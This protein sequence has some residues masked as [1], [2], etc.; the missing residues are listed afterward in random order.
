LGTA[1]GLLVSSVAFILLYV[2]M[3]RAELAS[4]RGKAAAQVNRL[5]QT[6]LE[7]AM[8]KR[9]LEGLRFIVDRLGRQPGVEAVFITNPGGEIRFASEPALLERSLLA[10][11][12]VRATTR[13]LIDAQG[14]D[15]LRSINPVANQP[16]CKECHGT[17]SEHPVNGIL[18]VDYNAA[19]IRQ[20]A[21]RT[22]LLLMGAGAAIV[23]INLAGGW[24]FI[25]RHVIKPIDHLR[26]TSQAL[27][28]GNLATRVAPRGD[29]ELAQLGYAFD[30]MADE[31]QAKIDELEHQ[32]AF[33]QDLIDAIPD[34]VRV[35]GSDYRVL[36][37]NRAYRQQLRLEA[38]DGVGEPC[39]RLSHASAQP[40][41]AT[42]LTCPVQEI[43]ARAEPV[44]ALHRHHRSDGEIIDVEIYAAP[45]Q[46]N[47]GGQ[48]Q[49]LVVES[50]RDLSK[51]IKYSHEQKLSELGKLATGVAHEIHNPL[52]SVRL[53]L[54]ALR[55][56]TGTNEITA[57][58]QEYLELV[59][60][61]VDKCVHVTERLLRL[62]MPPPASPELVDVA[63]VLHDTLGL[64]RWEAE[65]L[66]I[67]LR[68]DLTPS[69]RV[70]ASDSELRMVALNLVQNAFH[71]M[72]R[73]GE[74]TVSGR[75][76]GRW[77]LID[78]KDTGIG[79]DAEQMPRIFDPFYSRRAEGAKGTGLGLSI[80]R[81]IVENYDGEVTVRS[82]PGR[83]SVFS[84]RLPDPAQ[85]AEDAP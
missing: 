83:G 37:T 82:E 18:Y 78:V 32:G 6:S 4:E 17:A 9:D 54:H 30:R 43:G 84:V 46:A 73:G 15:I 20:Q 1:A 48:P 63:R 38:T 74:L 41:P 39:H 42:L 7:N 85:L 19:P 25:R 29:D 36:L 10:Q 72:P 16:Q 45:L 49:T 21:M 56:N 81:T 12:G 33:L 26:L 5:L 13:F 40:C 35:I 61:E 62:G 52:A 69:L 66:G 27:A 80:V 75:V 64:V 31:L 71:A 44:Q 79:I 53:A 8:L 51:Q 34:G 58:T 68:T 14:R 55:H 57:E 70:L 65:H 22:T 2:G 11:D 76:E 47:I 28:Q 60:R 59:D 77:V 50:I 24:W 3:Y 67:G 23:V